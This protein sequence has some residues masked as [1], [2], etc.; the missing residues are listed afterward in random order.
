MAIDGSI[1][2]QQALT[3]PRGNDTTDRPGTPAS[4]MIRYNTVA[5]TVE[6]YNGEKWGSI[7]GGNPALNIQMSNY[8]GGF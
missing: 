1:L 4:G 6:G 5:N 3:L 2:G 7:G 8:F